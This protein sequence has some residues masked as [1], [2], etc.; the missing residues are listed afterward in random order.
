MISRIVVK[1]L[2]DDA[3]REYIECW[4]LL[5]KM[6]SAKSSF[7]GEDMLSF[8]PR[9]AEMIFRLSSMYRSLHQEKR[10]F[11]GKKLHLVNQWFV[12]R[13][14]LI[15]QYQDAIST[16][17]AIGKSLGD[18]FAWI[19]YHNEPKHLARHLNHEKIFFT[20]PG[21]GGIG[22]LEFIKR[23]QIIDEHLIIYHGITD[24]LR[25]GDFSIVDLRNFK[26]AAIGELKTRQSSPNDFNLSMTITGTSEKL[27]NALRRQVGDLQQPNQAAIP[28]ILP[29]DMKRRL[30]KQ[31]KEIGNSFR[32]NK[33]KTSLD[34]EISTNFNMVEMLFE[35][36]AKL[37]SCKTCNSQVLIRVPQSGKGLWERITTMTEVDLSELDLV[38]QVKHI[39]VDESDD[40]AL[41]IAV[42]HNPSPDIKSIPGFMPLFWS[43]LDTS[44]V[45]ELLFLKSIMVSIF[46]PGPLIQ[47]IRRLG[48]DVQINNGKY[49]ITRSSNGQSATLEGA[50]YFMNMII[51][52]F[53]SEESV[54]DIL[55]QTI[56][57]TEKMVIEADTRIELEIIQQLPGFSDWTPK[58]DA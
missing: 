34:S 15:K 10:N 9:L 36:N 20:P 14:R 37:T 30:D 13:L 7:T 16:T 8:Q 54:L 44:L 32:V 29:D 25:L 21:V 51:T 17:I 50:S 6:R 2:I 22:E 57:A 45:E 47:G 3:E 12:N 35:G 24:I 48:F 53:I 49:T 58:S 38:E 56:S 5:C 27:I 43:P 40:N 42:I 1:S 28:E 11:I 23:I 26:L 31:V 46:N 52:Q 18:S 4:K 55:R 39:I 33:P 41:H 19:F